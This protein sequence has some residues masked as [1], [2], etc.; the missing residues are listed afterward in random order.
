MPQSD[1]SELLVSELRSKGEK[2]VLAE[3]CSGG[4]A[5]ALLTQIAGVSDCFCGSA[6]T[7]L[8]Q[9]KVDWLNVEK[10][11][12][13][14]YS[15]V[16]ETVARQMTLGVLAKTNDATL[17]A[18]ITG[19]LGPNAPQVLDGVVFMAFSKRNWA[20][21]EL[22]V[23]RVKLVSRERVARQREATETL[24]KFVWDQLKL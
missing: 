22:K 18:S 23:T 10:K 4:L 24:F 7:Y 15:A 5:A 3:S 13:E 19:H 2:I 17:A 20:S 1:Y 8:D 21:S 14:A 9:V 16:S 6:V 12:I 11:S